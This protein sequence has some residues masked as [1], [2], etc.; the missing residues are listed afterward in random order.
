[1]TCVQLMI[2]FTQN[3]NKIHNDLLFELMDIEYFSKT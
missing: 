2:T 3:E 1:M